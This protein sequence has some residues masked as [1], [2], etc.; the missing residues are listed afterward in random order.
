MDEL[1]VSHLI[2]EAEEMLDNKFRVGSY[3]LMVNTDD[4]QDILDKIKSILPEDIKTAEMILKRRDD[5]YMEAQSRADRIIS[6]AQNTA[7]NILSESELIR[8]VREKAAKIQEQV[9]ESCEEMKNK[10]AEEADNVRRTAYQEAMQTREGAQAYAE[11][12][13]N[14]LERDIEQVHRIVRNG[15]EYLSQ[16]KR[17]KEAAQNRDREMAEQ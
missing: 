14:N 8:A 17:A 15:Q 16:Q 11:Q 1:R 5:I 13:L 12:V 7:A 4:I 9:K 2:D 3:C 6:E 10:A